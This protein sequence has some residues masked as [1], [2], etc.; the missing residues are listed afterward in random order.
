MS[1]HHSKKNAWIGLGG[2]SKPVKYCTLHKRTLSKQQMKSKRCMAKNC[3]H[4][5]ELLSKYKW[6][7]NE[8]GDLLW[9]GL[10]Q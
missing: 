9:A 5:G 2:S 6:E 1:R 4:L 7:E 10:K 3:R 8:S